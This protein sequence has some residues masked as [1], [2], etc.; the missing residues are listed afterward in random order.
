MA[1]LSPS[2]SVLLFWILNYVSGAG[3]GDREGDSTPMQDEHRRQAATRNGKCSGKYPSA[4][5]D[6]AK[7]CCGLVTPDNKFFGDLSSMY[8]DQLPEHTAASFKPGGPGPV[9]MDAF[10]THGNKEAVFFVSARNTSTRRPADDYV[11]YYSRNANFS[12]VINTLPVI[13]TLG[14]KQS[15]EPGEAEQN[16]NR[17]LAGEEKD[18]FWN[19]FHLIVTCPIPDH[20]SSIVSVDSSG[21]VT[22]TIATTATTATTTTTT[23][24]SS[25]GS[26]SGSSRR[27]SSSNKNSNSNSNSDGLTAVLRMEGDGIPVSEWPPYTLCPHQV[28]NNRVKEKKSM[29][30]TFCTGLSQPIHPRTAPHQ[31]KTKN[32]VN[33]KRE[34]KCCKRLLIVLKNNQFIN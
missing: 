20:I 31:N 7:P 24:S 6:N 2:P 3:F 29:N 4:W 10:L 27:S 18:R 11:D 19:Q 1:H 28:T 5:M 15:L 33:V 12:A 8:E 26:S 34:K 30:L 32:V 17:Y 16:E 22:A 13:C 23:S 9:L 14:P 21:D 25:S